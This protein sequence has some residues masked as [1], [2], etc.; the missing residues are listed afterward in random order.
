MGA[1]VGADTSSFQSVGPGLY[2]GSVEKLRGNGIRIYVIYK[3]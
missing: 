2:L 1:L 3:Y